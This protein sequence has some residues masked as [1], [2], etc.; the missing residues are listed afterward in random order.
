MGSNQSDS[1]TLPHGLV[2]AVI[3]LE[4]TNTS[5]ADKR[6]NRSGVHSAEHLRIPVV[7]RA[8]ERG[9]GAADHDEVKVRDHEVGV[10]PVDIE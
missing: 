9:Q 4:P 7:D 10:V 8:E 2:A 5:A 3:V 6:P 1:G